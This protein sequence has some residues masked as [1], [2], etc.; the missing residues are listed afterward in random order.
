MAAVMER[1]VAEVTGENLRVVE[2]LGFQEFPLHLVTC[3]NP[4]CGY[5]A[6]SEFP[7]SECPDCGLEVLESKPVE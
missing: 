7:A 5:R 2:K 6:V 3:H 4:K 1:K